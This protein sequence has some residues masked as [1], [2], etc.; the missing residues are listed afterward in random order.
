MKDKR[1]QSKDEP[2]WSL[3]NYRLLKEWAEILGNGFSVSSLR[4]ECMAGRLEFIRTRPAANAK[5]LVS[6]AAIRAWIENY[7]SKW[8][9]FS[10]GG[11]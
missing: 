4:R 6:E 11:Q 7:A 5:I 9:Y 2:A 1:R 3:L 10:K 8:R